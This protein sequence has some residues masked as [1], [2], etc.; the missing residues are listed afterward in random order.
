MLEH[1]LRELVRR[2]IANTSAAT[3]TETRWFKPPFRGLLP[4]E[5]EHAAVFFG[6][7]RSRADLRT[8][9]AKREATGTAFV[10]VMGASGSGKSS[11]VKAGL[12][13]DLSLPGMIGRVGLCRYA[14]LRPSDSE[15]DPVLA[16]AKALLSPTALPEL[17]NLRHDVDTLARLLRAAPDDADVLIGQGLLEAAAKA[18][19][20]EHA[21]AKIAIVVD[22]LEE[23][24]TQ[25]DIT[26]LEREIFVRA[27]RALACS[28]KAWVIATMRSDFFDRLET[29][30]TL[31]HLSGEDGR[32][33]LLPP[34]DTEISQM[35]RQPAREAGLRFEVDGNGIG[36][37]D[38]IYEA[39]VRDRTALPLLSFLLDQLWR[40][41]SDGNILPLEAYSA[42]G[43]LEGALGRHAENVFASLGSE[44]QS[45]LPGAL[46]MLVTVSDD[47][48]TARPAL[49]SAFQPNTPQLAIVEAMLSPEARLLVIEGEGREARVRI[50]HEALL[51]SWP[52]A[53][54]S[55]SEDRSDLRLRGRLEIGADDW[56]ASP[57]RG[58]S[59]MLL[60][61]GQRLSEAED[62][63]RRRRGDLSPI[64]IQYVTE[65]AAANRRTWRNRIL[66]GA[67]AMAAIMIAIALAAPQLR[68]L[69][70]YRAE[71]IREANRDDIRGTLVAYST[72]NGSTASDGVGKN[73][74]FLE[75][76][77]HQLHDRT[78]DVNTLF[79]RVTEEVRSV[80]GDS[81]IPEISS[82]LSGRVFLQNPPQTRMSFGLAI[83]ASTYRHLPPLANG[84][85]DAKVFGAAMNAVGYDVRVIIDPNRAELLKAID[86]FTETVR[87][88]IDTRS[89]ASRTDASV[90]H[91]GLTDT[92]PA[93]GKGKLAMVY[94]SGS[95]IQ[96]KG[97]IYFLPVDAAPRSEDDIEGQMLNVSKLIQRL[98]RISDL[99]LVIIDTC[100]DDPFSR[101]AADRLR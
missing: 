58:R 71:R 57:V 84:S 53:R 67:A 16:L 63:L 3:A 98:Q 70:N 48:A 1:H 28:G 7:A 92:Y 21:E 42:L 75:S 6:R 59:S 79:A 86:D 15:N 43:G 20:T 83:G 68:D 81:Q 33:L 11:L 62:L 24:F 19:L 9:L 94:L 95:G 10:M 74:P 38:V 18:N 77:L 25:N 69:L 17:Q 93:Q 73:S 99:Q 101:N 82:S 72:A 97:E 52:R 60:H 34:T 12:L 87:T 45:A 41:R 89:H 14:I 23:L 50:A 40:H 96:V 37:D 64:V 8:L 66:A 35:I 80:T 44:I 47:N 51:T 29:L 36:V 13:P 4:F 49:M 90:Q 61:P 22:Q 2:R 32:Y 5:Y 91:R 46:R 39:A 54:E 100:R 88:A 85:S 55:L 26:Q 27:V 76:L 65:S 78:L 31:A 56:L 30:P